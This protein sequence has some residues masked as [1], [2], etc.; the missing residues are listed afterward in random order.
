MLRTEKLAGTRT[1]L[2]KNSSNILTKTFVVN[3]CLF[4][5]KGKFQ[6]KMNKTGTLFPQHVK[7][8]VTHWKRNSIPAEISSQFP[9]HMPLKGTPGKDASWPENAETMPTLPPAGFVWLFISIPATEVQLS[10]TQQYRLALQMKSRKGLVNDITDTEPH[11]PTLFM[12]SVC[13]M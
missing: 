10:R 12:T 13:W 3:W 4:F 11:M 8:T 2:E 6:H 1:P 7:T 9:A 5:F